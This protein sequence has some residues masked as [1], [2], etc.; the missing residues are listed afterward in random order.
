MTGVALPNWPATGAAYL[1]LLAAIAAQPD[2]T[3]CLGADEWTSDNPES[4][5]WAAVCC[6]SARCPALVDCRAAAD[7]LGAK[8]GVWA[9]H[10]RA[11]RRRPCKGAEVVAS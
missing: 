4:R 8:W 9:G 7:E 5:L 6:F 10:D 1:N 3:P 11:P 2:R